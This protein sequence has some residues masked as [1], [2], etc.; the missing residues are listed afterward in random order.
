[1]N[2]RIKTGLEHMQVD[3]VHDFLQTSYWAKDRTKEDLV[4]A[5]EHSLCF[6]MFDNN[7]QIAFAR[8]ITDYV[9]T[10]Y[11][12]DVIVDKNYRGQGI[13]K[14]LVQYLVT[15]P[16]LLSLKGVLATKDAH[17]LYHKFGFE[18]ADENTMVRKKK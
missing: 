17:G 2:Y 9:T 8:A 4:K 3:L 5:M 15:Y 18:N 6:G 14:Q 10:Y 16:S 1:M 11:V 13:G 7:K 12:C